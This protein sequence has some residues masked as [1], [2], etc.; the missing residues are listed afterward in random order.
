[1]ENYYFEG[2]VYTNGKLLNEPSFYEIGESM[3]GYLDEIDEALQRIND[4]E[5]EYGD[6]NHNQLKDLLEYREI[7]ERTLRGLL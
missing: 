7:N 5:K 3:I 6:C 1:M 4:I 2:D